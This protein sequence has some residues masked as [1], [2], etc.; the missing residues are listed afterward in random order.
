MASAAGAPVP[1]P[2]RKMPIRRL[3][4]ALT[5][6]PLRTAA[7]SGLLALALGLAAG[8]WH[9]TGLQQADATLADLRLRLSLPATPDQRVVIIDIDE[10]SLAQVGQWPWPRARIAALVDELVQRQQ[11]AALGLDAVFAEP[12]RA[13]GAG[14]DGDRLLSRAVA[15]GPVVLGYYL[16]SDRDGHRSGTLPTPLAG[17]SPW[18]RLLHWDGYGANIAPLAEA[19][20]A[21]GFFNAATDADGLVR[22]VPLLATLDGQLY[23]SMS[24]AVLRAGLG[25]AALRPERPDDSGTPGAITLLSAAQPVRIPLQPDGTVPVPYRGPGGPAGRSFTYLSAADV[26]AGTLPA[27]SLKGRYALLGFTAPGL[28]DLRTTPVGAAYPGVE[29]HAN[30]ISAALDGRMLLR[31][32]Q[33]RGYELVLLLAVGATLVLVLPRLA[34]GGALA[35]GLGLI[36]GVLALDATLYLRLGWIL[37]LAS[38]LLLILA[39]VVSNLALGYFVETR[40]RRALARQFA[41]YVPPE[42]VRQMLRA[43]HRYDMQARTQELTVMFCDL[44]GF[45]S[46]SEALPPRELQALLGDVL[47]RLTHVVHAHQGTIDKYIGDCVMAFWGAPVAMPDHARRAV[48]A[49]LAISAAMRDFN[50][51]RTAA[52]QPGLA[53]GI[54]LATGPMLVGNMGSDLRR[55]YTVIGDVVNLASRLEGLSRIYGVEI[56]ASAATRAE[57]TAGSAAPPHQWQRLDRVRVKGRRQAEDIYTVRAPDATPAP[58]LAEELGLWEQALALW[59]E[60]RFEEFSARVAALATSHPAVALYPIYL[61]RVQALLAQL[62]GPDWDGTT[63]YDTK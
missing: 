4:A 34:L 19:A 10:R 53:I 43:P 22:S 3:F 59:F 37:P 57:S 33:A 2:H 51:E 45:T 42:L 41:T 16:T 23:E 15:R 21:A 6:Y 12:E 32:P 60:G 24:L 49:A 52:S 62:P 18:P 58:E 30:V 39:T 40:S 9:W 7:S 56:V 54:G 1:G 48:D 46:L 35:L 36:A 27:G 63:V 55:A 31:P 50:A 28:M 44:R 13:A 8:P 5:R 14:E 17:L 11:V 29:V 25:Q 47:T 20:R 38:V 26:L 61:E